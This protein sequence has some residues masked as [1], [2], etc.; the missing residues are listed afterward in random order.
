MTFVTDFL[1]VEYLRKHG[2]AAILEGYCFRDPQNRE[3]S[4]P[5]ISTVMTASKA[6]KNFEEAFKSY[7][8]EK[9]KCLF[10]IL[11]LIR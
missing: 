5:L 10:Q 11:R 3:V 6:T 7:L 9:G 1:K 2:L 4:K 8:Y